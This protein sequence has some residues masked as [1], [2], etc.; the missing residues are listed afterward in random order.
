MGAGREGDTAAREVDVVRTLVRLADTLVAGYDQLDLLTDVARSCVR[1]LGADAAGLSLAGA[2]SLTFVAGSSEEPELVDLFGVAQHEGPGVEAFTTGAH[3]SVADV[4]STGERWPRWA[5]RALDLGIRSADG[6]PLRL[7]DETIGVL[8]VYARHPRSLGGRDVVVGQAFADMATIGL[9]HEE[10]VRD[11][12]TVRAQLESALRTR[13]AIEQAKGVMAER[14]GIPADEGFERLRRHARANR[15]RVED[16][17]RAI[18]D[19][20]LRVG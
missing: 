11:A 4:G 10:A 16:V 8:E 19:G 20:R 12:A 1:V 6:F 5:A 9:L 2:G 18:V 13:V 3:V 14:F 17:A 7:R 15:E